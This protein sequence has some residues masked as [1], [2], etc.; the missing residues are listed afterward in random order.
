MK[1]TIGVTEYIQRRSNLVA[2]IRQSVSEIKNK[3][4]IVV[5][6]S[7]TRQF[8]APDVPYP[9]HQCSY[10]RYFTGLN[11]SDAVLVI[12]AGSEQE[13]KSILYMKGIICLLFPF[14]SV[15]V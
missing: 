1:Q 13:P 14:S 2:K 9:F 6:R 15:T 10:F 5:L 12:T 7:A 3:P 8:Y 11:E 4:L